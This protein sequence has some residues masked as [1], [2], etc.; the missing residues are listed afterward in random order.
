MLHLIS[1]RATWSKPQD[2]I[3]P[4]VVLALAPAGMLARITRSA[5]LEASHGDYVRTARS[6]GLTEPQIVTWHILKNASIPI[7]TYTGPLLVEFVAFS[8][9]IEAMFGF[10]GFGREYYEAIT[11]LDYPMIMAITMIYGVIIILANFVIDLLYG[12]LDPRIR[13]AET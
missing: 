10:P 9:V 4:V 6:K 1:V 13:I 5:V 2:W 12:F 11:N 3:I 7:V 8:F